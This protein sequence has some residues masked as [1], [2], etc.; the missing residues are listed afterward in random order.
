MKHARLRFGPPRADQWLYVVSGAGVAAVSGKKVPLRA[1]VLLLIEQNDRHEI[2]NTGRGWLR[3]LDYYSPPAYTEVGDELPAARRN[4]SATDASSGGLRAQHTF[5]GLEQ[6][7]LTL[8]ILLPGAH[9]REQRRHAAH[10]VTRRIESL[11]HL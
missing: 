6:R 3:T 2:R 4:G 7:T 5:E 9:S 8:T 10:G 1:G 11:L